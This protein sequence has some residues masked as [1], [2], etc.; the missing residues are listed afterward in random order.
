MLGI[1]KRNEELHEVI[2]L[3]E[4]YYYAIINNNKQF[5]NYDYNDTLL[6]IYDESLHT[7]Q[8]EYDPIYYGKKL[9]WSDRMKQSILPFRYGKEIVSYNFDESPA[10]FQSILLLCKEQADYFEI[11]EAIEELNFTPKNFELFF[12]LFDYQKKEMNSAFLTT[13]ASQFYQKGTTRKQVLFH[14]LL[15]VIGNKDIEVMLLEDSYF[16][17]FLSSITNQYCM[18]Y[19]GVAFYKALDYYTIDGDEVHRINNYHRRESDPYALFYHPYYIEHFINL[20]FTKIDYQVISYLILDTLHRNEV[21]DPLFLGIVEKYLKASKYHGLDLYSKYTRFLIKNHNITIDFSFIDAFTVEEYYDCYDYAIFSDEFLSLLE[22]APIPVCR[23]TIERYGPPFL[24]DCLPYAKNKEE[25]LQHYQTQDAFQP[26]IA[27]YY[28]LYHLYDESFLQYIIDTNIELAS[29]YSKAFWKERSSH[30]NYILEL[31]PVLV[32]DLFVET[33]YIPVIKQ[34]QGSY[35]CKV[36]MVGMKYQDQTMFTINKNDYVYFSK[37][38]ENK[39]DHNAIYVVS[40]EGF[41]MGYISK[42]DTLNLNTYLH[43]PLYGVVFHIDYT[44]VTI[45]VYTTL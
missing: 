42:D 44:S 40:D 22:V 31:H 34:K 25:L 24:R 8:Y 29:K 3:F 13:I 2:Q 4:K 43:T 27:R 11:Q 38:L 18:E 6:Q 23:Y 36:T 33:K 35:L 5:V 30:M 39:Y 12:H 9:A 28:F 20:D 19:R 10:F 21:S 17:L 7:L 1:I 16:G 14:L 26:F 45:G 32:K 37:D 15:Q 41:I